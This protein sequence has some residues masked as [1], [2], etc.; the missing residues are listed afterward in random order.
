MKRF[1]FFTEPLFQAHDGGDVYPGETFYTVL[2]EDYVHRGVTLPRYSIIERTISIDKRYKFKVNND[3]VWYFRSESNADY[4]IRIWK[5]QDG[6][7]GGEVFH[8]QSD[9][10]ITF[11]RHEN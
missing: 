11:N 2:K 8:K 5:K 6:I 9:I 3:M 7:S 10:I 4:L 1:K